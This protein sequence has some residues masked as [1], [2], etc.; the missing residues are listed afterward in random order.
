MAEVVS[1][2]TF[3][4][5]WYPGWKPE[6]IDD[7][8]WLRMKTGPFTK[9]DE[10]P[11]ASEWDVMQRAPRTEKN[12]PKFLGSFDDIWA[13]RKGGARPPARTLRGV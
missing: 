8:Y 4:D 1:V 2:D 6:H 10:V 12:V 5:G 7:G 13:E 3:L 11:V 9:V